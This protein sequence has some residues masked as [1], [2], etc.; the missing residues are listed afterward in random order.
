MERIPLQRADESHYDFSLRAIEACRSRAENLCRQVL[1]Q[2]LL[3]NRSVHVGSPS[4]WHI[5]R[6][7][8]LG[9]DR[10]ASLWVTVDGI[11]FNFQWT[12]IR[13]KEDQDYAQDRLRIRVS[14]DPRYGWAG[15]RSVPSDDMIS[16]LEPKA[17]HFDPVQVV[18]A[19]E[20]YLV[21]RRQ[22][23]QRARA[24]KAF[25]EKRAAAAKGLR[26]ATL[27]VSS[28][29]GAIGCD[30][31]VYKQFVN[32]DTSQP[33]RMKARLEFKWDFGSP[34]DAYAFLVTLSDA[35]AKAEAEATEE[36]F[37]LPE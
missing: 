3:R 2:L 29:V 22:A 5:G 26:D 20:R 28:H 1:E 15:E 31:R 24:A 6:R 17:K 23:R 11:K 16:L 14:R 33:P 27:Q 18:E 35:F 21:A 25:E 34:E 32:D 9:R 13:D 37:S 36:A 4:E 8:Y 30:A 7:G 10:W 12:P 19:L